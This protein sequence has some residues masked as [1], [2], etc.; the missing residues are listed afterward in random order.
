MIRAAVVRSLALLLLA[1]ALETPAAP[2]AVFL[3]RHAEKQT[4]SNEREVPLSEAG[5]TRARHLAG[6]LRDA[7]IVAIY[8]TDTVRT[9]S[10]AEPLAKER[11]L[12]PILYDATTAAGLAALAARIA[13]EHPEENVLVVGHSNTIAPL[14]RA[15]GCAEEISIGGADY[16]GLWI[17]VPAGDV[18]G[19]GTGARTAAPGLIRLRQ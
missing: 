4:E 19:S 18:S 5:R 11:H 9:L 12:I 13:K 7:G 2:A 14:A 16:D 10:T 1:A 3:V 15:L 8:S 17:V 6:M